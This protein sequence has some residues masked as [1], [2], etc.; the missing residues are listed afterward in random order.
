[1]ANVVCL[2]TSVWI[3]LVTPEESSE[4]VQAAAEPYLTSPGSV[5]VAPAWQWVEIQSVLRQKVRR[6][7]LSGDEAGEAFGL[8]A[9]F[10]VQ[11]H[12]G[13]ALRERTWA[14]ASAFELPTAYD[15]C[16]LACT[17]TAGAPGDQRLFLTLDQALARDLGAQ[18]PPY[19]RVIR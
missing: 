13:P 18:P 14:I 15:A 12:D 16:L 1:M 8:F 7:H 2:D 17:E 10:P 4:A 3:A 9:L 5:L 6:G 11:W 19:V